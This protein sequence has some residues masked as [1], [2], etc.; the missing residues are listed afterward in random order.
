MNPL[1]VVRLRKLMD[2]TSGKPDILIGL[3]DGPV[4]MDLPTLMGENIRGI[5]AEF[6]GACTAA[7]SLAC[8]HGTFVAGILSAKRTSGA[9]SICPNCTLL[10]RP[11][12]IEK[13]SENAQ[14]PSANP[15]ELATAIIDAVKAG[16]R[17]INLSAALVYSSMRK[18][19]ALEEA[20][21]YA[22]FH[23]VILV[24]AAGNQG[25]V[26]ST[27]I[28]RHPWVIAVTACDERGYPLRYSNLGHS[29][30]RQGLIA[31]G[32]EIV[33]LGTDGNFLTLSGTSAAAPFVTGTIALLYSIFPD[34]TAVEMKS[35]LIQSNSIRRTSI[36][37]PLLN[38]WAAYQN[39]AGIRSYQT[40]QVL[41]IG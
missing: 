12:F 8:A 10:V 15:Q 38:A 14:M 25:L 7:N 36:L 5:R 34:A 4:A 27:V 22:A 1:D 32:D 24:V 30:G 9:P 28:T 13:M 6:S 35:A 40:S 31:P 16:A 2:L 17:V 29:I 20:L 33:S 26:G 23:H 41:A 19:H 37:P 11:I 21:D 18:E 39:L 3:I